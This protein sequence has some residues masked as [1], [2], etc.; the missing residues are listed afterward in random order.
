[1][2]SRD[3]AYDEEEQL[4]RAIAASK[5]GDPPESTDGGTRRTKRA[6]SDSEEYVV[7][8]RG[9]HNTYILTNISGS[10]K[11]QS[12]NERCLGL[13]RQ[14]VRL[15]R[16]NYRPGRTRT[17]RHEIVYLRRYV[18]QPPKITAQRKRAKNGSAKDKM[19]LPSGKDERRGGTLKV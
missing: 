12:D 13:L 3:A 9:G 15:H 10:K 1:M 11:A 18:E 2:N 16:S 8:A 5:G 19:L 7:L 17:A 6:R 4:R 14:H